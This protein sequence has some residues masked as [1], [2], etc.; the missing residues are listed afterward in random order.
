MRNQRGFTL[1]ELLI[2][3]AIIAAM[4][5]GVMV[6]IPVMGKKA[7]ANETRALI[8]QVDAVVGMIKSELGEYPPTDTR[9]IRIG[10]KKLGKEL[11]GND[12]NLG[13]ET[14]CVLAWMKD[15]DTGKKPETK[16]LINTD[17]DEAPTN[18][19]SHKKA[20][21]FELMDAYQNPLI[22]LHHRDYEM[23]YD[24]KP[25]E[26]AIAEDIITW[27]VKAHRDDKTQTYHKLD[28]YQLFSAGPDNEPG[29]EDDIASFLDG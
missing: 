18:I 12:T 24:Y 6:L 7:R 23:S 22:Y 3:M 25:G 14:I 5:A 2:V 21:L 15:L 9:E 17:E 27:S 29:T 16:H 8:S 26:D 11:A 1:I 20:D 4:A 28:S 10:K 13:I 19:T